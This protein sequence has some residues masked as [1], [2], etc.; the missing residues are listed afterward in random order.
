[1]SVIFSKKGFRAMRLSVLVT[2]SGVAVA[3]FLA[4]TSYWYWQS[5]KNGN[6]TSS[7]RQQD[8]RTRLETA[9]RERDDLRDSEQTYKVLTTRGVFQPEQ[10]LE[11]VEAFA[12]LKTRHQLVAFEYEVQPQRPLKLSASVSLPAVDVFGSRIKFKARANHDG[13]LVAF[14]DEFPRMQRGFFPLDRCVIKRT[15]ESESA[16]NIASVTKAT[17]LQAAVTAM[18]S[19]TGLNTPQ[20]S[21]DADETS[22][23]SILKPRAPQ[24]SK[25][26]SAAL[27]AD[28]SLEW[29][30]MV[31]KQKIAEL[32]KQSSGATRS[33]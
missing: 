3:T 19:S 13:D 30:T 25:T 6:Q 24:V 1:M 26:D 23:E 2:L 16:K 28:C 18:A 9:R 12:A 29:I 10:R 33:Q 31:D 7:A 21:V 5:E 27:E 14:L 11:L 8:T 15:S 32:P 4:G 17:G 20:A 22:L